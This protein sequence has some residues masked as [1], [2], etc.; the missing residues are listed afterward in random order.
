MPVLFFF[1]RPTWDGSFVR[2]LEADKSWKPRRDMEY[3]GVYRYAMKDGILN[4]KMNGMNATLCID[5]AGR[6]VLPKPV[7]EQLQLA[8]GDS[9]EMQSSE[10][11]IILRPVRGAGTMRKEQGIWV[12]RTGQRLSAE[13]V[14]RTLRQVR[15]ARGHVDLGSLRSRKAGKAR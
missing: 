2:P 12:L 9:L 1:L 13:V 3:R 6:L 5:K 10:D 15:N 14:N 8:A 4:G 7:R 11:Q